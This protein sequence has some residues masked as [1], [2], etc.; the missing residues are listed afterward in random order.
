MLVAYSRVSLSSVSHRLS[1]NCFFSNIG[2]NLLWASVSHPLSLSGLIGW[3]KVSSVRDGFPFALLGYVA[4]VHFAV[5]RTERREQRG[6]VD[7]QRESEKE[8]DKPRT[9]VLP[10]LLLIQWKPSLQSLMLSFTSAALLVPLLT[11]ALH[12]K[13]GA[14]VSVCSTRAG[15]QRPNIQGTFQPRQH[16]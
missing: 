1:L 15:C 16:P 12:Y 2:F 4:S 8:R 14:A 10:R 6:E 11:S 7:F 5:Q 3:Q 9:R 13:D